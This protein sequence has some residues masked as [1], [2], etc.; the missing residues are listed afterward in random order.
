MRRANEETFMRSNRALAFVFAL[1][2]SQLMAAPA[3]V[4]RP[5]MPEPGG[6]LIVTDP[7]SKDTGERCPLKHTAVRAEISGF[8]SRVFVTQEFS[9]TTGRKIEAV[10]TFPLP[11][12]AAIDD[13]TM[14]VGSRTIKAKIKEREEA[15]KIY[16]D[17]RNRGN[18][19]ALLDQERPNVFKQAVANIEPGASVK[20]T[21]SYIE[22]LR[23]EEG[24]Y[25]WSFPM[26]VGPRYI[27]RHAPESAKVNPKY[28]PPATR[29][30]HDLSLEVTLDA[31]MPLTDFKSTTHEIAV[32][33]KSPSRATLKLA[34]QTTIPNK[35][36][37]LQYGV[38]GAKV[39]DA[40]IAHRGQLGGYFTFVLQPPERVVAEDVTPKELIFVLD[41]SGSMSGFPLEKAK[42]A[43][44]Y[45][46]DGLY[47]RD[48]F[49]LI[50]FAGDT[51]ILFPQPV[52]ATKENLAT[53]QTFLSG[54]RGAGGTEMMKA[55]RAALAPSADRDHV[56]IVCFMTDGYVGNDFEIINEVKRNPGARVF[57]FGIGSS[58]NR[59]LLSKM[60]EEG[61]GEVE[62]VG[63]QDD[64]S[65]AARRFHERV[66]SPLLTD[67]SIEWNGLPVMDV[68]PKRIPDL[69]SA[70]PIY[71]HGRYSEAANGTLTLRGRM[72]G[73]PVTRAVKVTLPG[74]QPENA[75][76][77]TLWARERV[78]DLMSRDWRSA[79][80]GNFDAAT[81]S[82]VIRLG[83]KFRL[84]TQFT[85]FVAVE[86]QRRTEGGEPVTV[87][88]P[89]E[90]PDGVS[91]EGALGGQ[92]MMAA[93]NLMAAPRS[94]G[95]S[96]AIS[97]PLVSRRK[98][99]AL[100]GQRPLPAPPPATDRSVHDSA[101]VD[102]LD[103]AL[104]AEIAKP[105]DTSRRVT[106]E[107]WLV[108]ASADVLA[109]LKAVG[110]TDVAAPRVA[111]IRRGTIRVDQLD[112]LAQLSGVMS[113][114]A[115]AK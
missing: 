29:A 59:F 94:F 90:M 76:M 52:P 5:P 60:A 31:G 99:E 79:N 53:A 21:I 97:V 20:I 92:G 17:A 3:R 85:S 61:R 57:S 88:V 18:V 111:K 67:V 4:P 75:A 80:T 12:R 7:Y 11:S 56:R 6:E 25:E 65:A 34:S 62:F 44:K 16:E 106:V 37:V 64:G 104:R 8:V 107:V 66:R 105:L 15:R 43:M 63:L 78:E 30:G 36:F 98:S 72:N 70:K 114:K 32:D 49:N 10:Y 74:S 95:M 19:A 89:V 68:Y 112:A 91:H 101:T 13:M 39:S 41:T 58:V 45:A 24:G 55:I 103:A 102:K 110:F 71:V 50:T 23:Y 33:R 77:A 38:A 9:N 35:D 81:K 27:P 26:V 14:L 22:T 42:E 93:Q 47:P 28:A 73:K 109:K 1:A 115:V 46:L 83:I 48:T 40:L 54:R 69:F 84:M 108:D 51:H 87:E 82:E 2:A 113:V 96:A 86:E 100:P